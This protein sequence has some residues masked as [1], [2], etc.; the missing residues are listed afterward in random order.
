MKKCIEY[1]V[2]VVVLL[3]GRGEGGLLRFRR[4]RYRF[5]VGSLIGNVLPEKT[6]YNSTVTIRH[7]IIR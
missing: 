4:S 6:F 7:S 2:F 1:I 3:V 5:L